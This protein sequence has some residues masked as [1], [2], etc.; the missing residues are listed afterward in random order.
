MRKNRRSNIIISMYKLPSNHTA[1]ED[2]N[3]YRK[4]ESSFF[5]PPDRVFVTLISRCVRDD[6]PG[7][8]GCN[9]IR[10][11][12]ALFSLKRRGTHKGKIAGV[13]MAR[14]LTPVT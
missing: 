3:V 13:D 12:G 11:L 7:H 14:S 10:G 9:S 6:V 8:V 5:F 1:A 2:V 4:L